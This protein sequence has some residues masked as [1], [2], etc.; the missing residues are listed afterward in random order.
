MPRD[1]KHQV[2]SGLET[3]FLAD[4]AGVEELFGPT[5]RFYVPLV[6]QI[7]PRVFSVEYDFE[8]TRAFKEKVRNQASGSAEIN[9]ICWREIL[10][11]A[12]ITVSASLYRTCRLIDASVRENSAS[13]LPGWAS[14][15]RALLEAT[16]DSSEA[17]RAIPYTLAEHHRWIRTCLSGRARGLSSS[18]ELEDR[19]IHFTHARRLRR[20]EKDTVPP[21]HNAKHTGEYIGELV[22]C[23]MPEAPTLYRELCELSHPA[24]NSVAY[25]FSVVD[26]GTAF[27]VEPHRDRYMIDALVANHR[28]LFEDLLMVSINPILLSLRVFHAFRLFPNIPELRK[29]D[30]S[31]IPAWAT[32]ETFLKRK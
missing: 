26:E 32:I 15:T 10:F 18:T 31:K 19:M 27:R 30:F 9:Q 12:H 28:R 7:I 3:T 17:L 11:R 13:N 14:C 25:F 1:R 8:E 23:G 16:G 6:R 5:A 20:D 29:V 22:A 2:A 21:S 4:H 24:A